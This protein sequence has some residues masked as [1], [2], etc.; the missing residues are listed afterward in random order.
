MHT[1]NDLNGYPPSNLVDR[2]VGR[3]YQVVKEVYL[4]IPMLKEFKDSP[5]LNLLQTNIED[6]KKLNTNFDNIKNIGEHLTEVL[7]VPTWLE[8]I[9]TEGANQTKALQ[10][11]NKQLQIQNTTAIEEK[12][13]EVKEDLASKVETAKEEIDNTLAS[14][15]SDL[16]EYSEQAAFSYR[17]LGY[18]INYPDEVFAIEDLEP[19]TLVKEGDH[20]ITPSG[21]IHKVLQVDD[22]YGK[23]SGVLA[24]IQGP[25]GV[26]GPRGISANEILM[27]PDPEKH[28]LEVYGRSTGDKIGSLELWGNWTINPDPTL[29]FDNRLN[30]YKE[31]L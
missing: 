2:L 7:E 19:N 18:D 23:A 10:D 27:V 17:Y 4:N 28:F 30:S 16:V 25:R 29:A 22:N 12:A 14:A 26:P 24:N 11:L 8:K 3:S 9:K 20:F 6:I 31:T 5:A 21:N 13:N 1:V 15:L